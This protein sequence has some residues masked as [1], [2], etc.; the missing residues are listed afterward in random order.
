MWTNGCE[1]ANPDIIS[2]LCLLPAVPLLL[3]TGTEHLNEGELA[4]DLLLCNLF[5][6]APQLAGTRRLIPHGTLVNTL[7]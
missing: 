3:L 5:I 6:C 1:A 4:G 2:E 7:A